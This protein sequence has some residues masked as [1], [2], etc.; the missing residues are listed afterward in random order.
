MALELNLLKDIKY[1]LGERGYELNEKTKKWE[2][3]KEGTE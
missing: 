2:K 3:K 1:Q